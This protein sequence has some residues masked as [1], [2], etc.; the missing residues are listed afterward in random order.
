MFS[1][2][3]S[4]ASRTALV[5]APLRKISEHNSGTKRTTTDDSAYLKG[6]V[7]DQVLFDYTRLRIFP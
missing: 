4:G 3:K 5:K 7:L 1:L 6:L 2:I